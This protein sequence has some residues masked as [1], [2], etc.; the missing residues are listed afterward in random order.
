MGPTAALDA[1]EK[2]II[3]CFCQEL[4]PDYL[5]MQTTAQALQYSSSQ[6]RQNVAYLLKARRTG[7]PNKQP[8]LANG[9]ETTATKQTMKQHPLLRSRF[10]IS[11]N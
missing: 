5:V 2:K 8:L 9:S 6:P 7:E 3:S 10:L 4:N 1:V 11:N